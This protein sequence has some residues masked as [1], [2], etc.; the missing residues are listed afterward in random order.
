MRIRTL[1]LAGF[2]VVSLPGI[3][4]SAWLAA[5]AYGAWDDAVRAHQDATLISTT[6]RLQTALAVEIGQLS[7]SI[8]AAQPD[9]APLRQAT[10]VT[11]RLLA[12]LL[13]GL[14]AATPGDPPELALARQVGPRIAGLRGR[15]ETGWSLP[16]AARDAALPADLAEARV[17]L[18]GG[19][20][21]LGA[22]V[23]NRLADLQPEL[24][25]PIELATAVMEQR[26]QVGRS[27]SAILGW[28]AGRP[29]DRA[30]Y[31]TVLGQLGRA[32]AAAAQATRLAAMMADN[33]ALQ[34]ALRRHVALMQETVLPRLRALLDRVLP[35]WAGGLPD[36]P[37]ELA[38]MRRW[39]TPMQAELLALR[40]VALDD[41]LRTADE[42][43]GAARTGF[44][45]ACA[46]LL[47][48]LGIAAGSLALLLRRLVGPINGLTRLL[49][50]LAEGELALEIPGRQRGDELGA[51]ARAVETLRQGSEQRLEMQ[52]AQQEG[53]RAELARA[54]R[55]SALLARFEED[56]AG[57][58]RVVAAAA[59][60]LDATAAG[61]AG[62]A[63]DGRA[64]ADAVAGAA[65]QA[66]GNVQ[67]V[68][69]AT[70]QLTASIAEVARQVR[71]GASQARAAAEAAGRA[72]QTVRGLAEAGG[73]IGEVVGLINSI[74]GQTNLL[75]LNA[76]I[77]AARAGEAGKGFAV[78]AS[79]VKNLATQTARATEEIGQQIGAMQAE[80]QRTVQAIG[81]IA[82]IIE[83]L[84]AATAHVAEA[85][86]QQAE[87]TQEIGR[88]VAEAARGTQ[89]A[90]RHAEGVSE[91]AG[92]TGSA[93][94]EVRAA[95]GELA[96]RAEDLR[97]RMDAFLGDI[98]A[99]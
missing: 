30:G 40:D 61:M 34:A 4:A 54:Q 14:P 3:V 84:N 46:M 69:A 87:A 64:H 95:A 7:T 45:I 57:V 6:Q 39:T 18:V 21:Q 33:A 29:I 82:R 12:A 94:G 38:A 36:W 53:Q 99:A 98:R 89:A 88:A 93:A 58:L 71:D 77:E 63:A 16:P 48:I 96:R 9:L 60:E 31:E 5:R 22:R 52:A 81:D 49:G 1:F 19:L 68:A 62:I 24:L 35:A 76:T 41:A 75:A 44:L 8:L 74:A 37:E 80:T 55:V 59:T 26:D 92:R 23:A 17:A 43:A 66:S 73:R 11:D 70:E 25:P 78:V 28:R 83:A 56:T 91:D 15:A 2:G 67:T 79:E 13:A 72:E 51:M 42:H 10:P 86:G 97:G 85:A 32:E 50:R 90:S 47:A 20:A 27:V 65:G